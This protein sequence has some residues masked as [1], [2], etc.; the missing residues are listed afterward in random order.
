MCNFALERWG[1]ELAV[2]G[3]KTKVRVS[4]EPTQ[5]P[6]FCIISVRFGIK[7]G[8]YASK[9]DFYVFLTLSD[10]QGAERE[11]ESKLIKSRQTRTHLNTYFSTFNR[12][13]KHI[14]ASQMQ[15]NQHNAIVTIEIEIS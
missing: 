9:P 1:F 6:S 13:F 11:R 15:N 10:F 2:L 3:L 5:T 12:C 4:S 14:F 8:F 7:R